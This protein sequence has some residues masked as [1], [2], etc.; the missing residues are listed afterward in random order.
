MG[1]DIFLLDKR[2][3]KPKLVARDTVGHY[4]IMIKESIKNLPA[5]MRGLHPDKHITS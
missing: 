3:F 2:D 4:I 5:L 1:V